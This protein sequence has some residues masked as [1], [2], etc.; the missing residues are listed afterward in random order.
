MNCT[1]FEA[2][3]NQ[4]LDARESLVDD[5]HLIA[6]ALHCEDCSDSLQYYSALG[7]LE[8]ANEGDVEAACFDVSKLSSLGI[9]TDLSADELAQIGKSYNAASETLS[10]ASKEPTHSNQN[11][12]RRNRKIT[13]S[14]ANDNQRSIGTYHYAVLGCAA[15]M[16]FLMLTPL[17]TALFTPEPEV[18][19]LAK[20][21]L[22]SDSDSTPEAKPAAQPSRVNMVNNRLGQFTDALADKRLP[23][24]QRVGESLN[25]VWRTIQEDEYFLPIIGQ[26]ALLL[27]RG[28]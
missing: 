28:T 14:A 25:S 9:E 2:H 22:R 4:K 1:E 7:Q 10:V 8:T 5:P 11:A 26:G 16:I 20:A 15:S 3:V 19:G 6:H 12:D 27:V 13:T 17:G 21:E 23:E 24:L 18:S